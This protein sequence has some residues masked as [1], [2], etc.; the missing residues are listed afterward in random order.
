MEISPKSSIASQVH[1]T[2]NVAIASEQ[3]SL[4]TGVAKSTKK[5]FKNYIE[6]KHINIEVNISVSLYI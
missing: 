5:T 3:P 1:R 6:S 2:S 4:T